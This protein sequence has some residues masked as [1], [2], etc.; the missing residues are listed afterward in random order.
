MDPS[1]P[2]T[3][4]D[5]DRFLLTDIVPLICQQANTFAHRTAV[6]YALARTSRLFYEPALTCLWSE[7]NS[8]V[9][10]I[11]CLPADAWVESR[12]NLKILSLTRPILGSDLAR[13]QIH[14]RLVKKITVDSYGGL[15]IFSD[16]FEG[17]G[18]ALMK[19]RVLF[20]PNID[21]LSWS[22]FYDHDFAFIGMFLNRNIRKL[23][24]YLSGD[25]ISKPCNRAALIHALELPKYCPHIRWLEIGG[26][27]YHDQVPVLIVSRTVCGLT[28]L[29][30]LSLS[31]LSPEAFTHVASLPNLQTL[32]LT[33][34]GTLS[35]FTL[36]ISQ[37]VQFPALQQAVFS[38]CRLVEVG[39]A[40]FH[41]V[42]HSPLKQL[43][44]HINCPSG[45]EL[46][47]CLLQMPYTHHTAH[48]S[49]EVLSLVSA[50][51]T[52]EGSGLFAGMD[53]DM[54]AMDDDISVVENDMLTMDALRPLF[55][56]TNL[57]NLT[58]ELTTGFDV[59]DMEIGRA[60][61]RLYQFTLWLPK[62]QIH[63]RPR[64]TLKGVVALGLLCPNLSILSIAFDASTD[65]V[66][67]T[68]IPQPGPLAIETNSLLS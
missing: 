3:V 37:S 27:P 34:V 2:T 35:P 8:I 36:P 61:P 48:K 12:D 4:F 47:E 30:S 14:A 38:K 65:A 19:E 45:G 13:M 62:S 41:A 33:D 24:I 31:S 25:F 55:I 59:D 58:L 46:E 52:M 28:N 9:P 23:S 57:S 5:S 44:L 66:N 64:V 11:K 26:F 1:Q 42:S 60:W 56:F 22:H 68:A 49:L 20:L 67:A 54:F 50:M 63:Q 16:T 40:L 21:E 53:T 15:M 29:H 51:P 10:L 18:K 39:T 43:C 17:L 6:L 32:Q 7:L